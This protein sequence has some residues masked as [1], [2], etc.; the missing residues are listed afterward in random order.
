M[1][2]FLNRRLSSIKGK[3]DDERE[4]HISITSVQGGAQVEIDMIEDG[5]ATLETILLTPMDAAFFVHE[6]EKNEYCACCPVGHGSDSKDIRVYREM[7]DNTEWHFVGCPTECEIVAG[8]IVAYV[9][10]LVVEAMANALRQM[11]DSLLYPSTGDVE[12][13]F[14]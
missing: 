12:E 9:P 1:L 3:G 13:E 11:M 7:A 2:K 4:F 10:S 5:E 6:T 8:D 14:G